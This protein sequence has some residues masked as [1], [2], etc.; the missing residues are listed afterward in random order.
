M[1]E[2]ITA[3]YLLAWVRELK[4]EDGGDFTRVLEEQ[5]EKCREFMK[6]KGIDE[7]KTVF[8][9]SRSQ[10]FMDIERD[11][12]A[13]L[14]LLDKD[15]LAAEKGDL[16]G[17]LFELEKRNVEILTVQGETPGLRS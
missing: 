16:E 8:Y 12:V 9:R 14:I 15:R 10:L 11:R 6:Q 4:P 7:E 17:A 5:K 2:K 3:V 1:E 13:R